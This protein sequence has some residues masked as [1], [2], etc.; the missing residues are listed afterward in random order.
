MLL[1]HKHAY[2]RI[3]PTVQL[4]AYFFVKT[5]VD[6]LR[7]LKFLMIVYCEDASLFVRLRG[8]LFLVCNFSRLTP[9]PQPTLL[10]HSGLLHE[11][12]S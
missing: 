4:K 5:D 3:R 11:C 12:H 9:P 7:R 2:P 6:P 10:A 8:T 1:L